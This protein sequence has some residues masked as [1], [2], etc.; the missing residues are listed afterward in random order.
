MNLD[1]VIADADT[2][3]VVLCRSL[4]EVLP[5]LPISIDGGWRTFQFS[6]SR[7]MLGSAKLPQGLVFGAFH[8]RTFSKG[9][10]GTTM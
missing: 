5:T 1:H 9:L 4:V 7:V 3:H 8:F 2:V 6:E 10:H